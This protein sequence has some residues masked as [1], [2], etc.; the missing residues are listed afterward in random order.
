MSAAV[1]QG[2]S[3][4]LA[5]KIG[6]LSATRAADI[7]GSKV[8]RQTLLDEM[9]V[10]I[11]T[12]TATAIPPT[13]DIRKGIA[14][15]KE[16]IRAYKAFH[17]DKRIKDAEIIENA[18]CES[19]FSSFVTCSPDGLVNFHALVPDPRDGGVETK[20]LKPTNHFRIVDT[21]GARIEK[22]YKDHFW[23]P[24]WSMLVTGRAWWDLF[25]YCKELPVSM[26]YFMRRFDRD[27]AE[28][29]S[30]KD[31]ALSF[32]DMLIAKLKKYG[33]AI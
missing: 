13:K 18:Y 33:V 5:E 19:G 32:I 7:M 17:P 23:Q 29:N 9:V 24:K 31:A 22:D 26:R 28:I 14:D 15:Q 6:A 4:W 1:V 3:K 11:V 20:N 8:V 21:D 27:E 2:G 30:M 10:E 16:A 12:T 25:Y